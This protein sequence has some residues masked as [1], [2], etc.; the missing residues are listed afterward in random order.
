M[1]WKVLPALRSPKGHVQPLESAKR[2]D[3]TGL[4]NVRL[5]HRDLVI[6]LHEVQLGEDGATGQ[7]ASEVVDVW[8]RIPVRHSGIVE[9]PVVA[10]GSP[11]AVGLRD[12]VQRAGP[13]GSGAPDDAGVLHPT[14]LG[15]GRLEL[16]WIQ[17]AIPCMDRRPSGLD[18]MLN[19]VLGLEVRE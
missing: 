13:G 11:G 7:A 19:P 15:L 6:A 18:V 17:T 4:G 12:H 14:E 5:V 9:R 2:R 10:A 1:R 16:D 3:N 8:N